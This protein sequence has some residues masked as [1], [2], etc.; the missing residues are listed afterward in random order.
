MK[1]KEHLTDLLMGIAWALGLL[2]F[3]ITIMFIYAVTA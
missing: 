1:I 3:I 2:V